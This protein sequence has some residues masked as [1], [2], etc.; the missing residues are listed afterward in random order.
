MGQ[1][2]ALAKRADARSNLLS[3]LGHFETEM[4]KMVDPLT[5]SYSKKIM[6]Q[7]KNLRRLMRFGRMNKGKL[8]LAALAAAAAGTY[9]LSG[10]SDGAN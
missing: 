5:F 6:G 10:K 3:S 2:I 1:V 9:A 8:A 7:G 4:P